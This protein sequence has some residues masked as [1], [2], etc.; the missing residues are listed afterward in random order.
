M[1]Q[2][3]NQ[4]LVIEALENGCYAI[5][6]GPNTVAIISSQGYI[7]WLLKTPRQKGPRIEKVEKE[8]HL[9]HVLGY[10]L[11]LITCTPGTTLQSHDYR[12]EGDR[13]VLVGNGK[14]A[15]GKFASQVTAVLSVDAKTHR[16][17]WQMRTVLTC[18]APEPVTLPWIEFNN[19]Y[20]SGTGRCF[21][22]APQKLFTHTLMKDR[23]GVVW[24]FPH[25]HMMHYSRKIQTLTFATPALAGFFQDGLEAPV[26][27]VESSTLPPDWAICD[28]F[29][30]LHCGARPQG[31]V[32]PGQSHTFEYRVHYLGKAEARKLLKDS[33]PVRVSADD[34]KLHEYPRFELGKN[35]FT[36]PCAIDAVDDSS[37]FR[38]RPP[39]LVWDRQTGHKFKGSLRLTNEKDEQII[40]SAEPPTQIPAATKLN[41]RAMVKTKDVQGK[42]IYLRVRYHTFVWHPTPHVEWA[43]TLTSVPVN[44]TTTDWVEIA[45]PELSVPKEHF[46]YLVWIDVIL[47]GKGRA[48]LT[49]VDVDL[50]AAEGAEEFAPES[51]DWSKSPALR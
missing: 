51:P 49:D 31:P 4:P 26:V 28:M 24:Q 35:H 36:H 12:V 21:L 15:D 50:Q 11:L 47:E 34:F 46:D 2:Q 29:Y 3:A 25:Q 27:T 44:G 45:V 8:P 16:Y 37:G 33:R 22:F 7:D 1:S 5:N 43:I 32:Q 14:S 20:P 30:D 13:V 6:R 17:Q 19:V 41:L 48:W 9:C 40:W 38:Q 23:E 39:Q 18:L 10:K 42:G